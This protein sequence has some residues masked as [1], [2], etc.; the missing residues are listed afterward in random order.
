MCINIEFAVSWVRQTTCLPFIEKGTGK[1]VRQPLCSSQHVYHPQFPLS[2]TENNVYLY[3][4]RVA[5]V[6]QKDSRSWRAQV[7]GTPKIIIKKGKSECAKCI[8]TT[9]R[10]AQVVSCC[11]WLCPRKNTEKE[12]WGWLRGWGGVWEV[13]TLST[14]WT[15]KWEMK[16]LQKLVS[17]CCEENA[18]KL[19]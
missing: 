15:Q 8:L 4:S 7:G 19:C 3:S 16:K 1:C 11:G 6:C 14:N 10:T 13:C 2:F 17:R 12:T 5:R 18:L 9:T